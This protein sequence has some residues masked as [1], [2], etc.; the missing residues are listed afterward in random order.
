MCY[1]V[2]GIINNAITYDASGNPLTYNGYTF[3]WQRGRQLTSFSGNGQNISYTYD[4]QGRRTS[5]TV[6]G[7]TF[8]YTYSGDLL[9]RQSDGTNTLDF[10]YD[11]GGVAV[12][13][14]YNGT[15]YFY[16]RNLQGDVVAVTDADGTLVAEYAYDAWGNIMVCSGTMA[17][18]NP[19][20]Y[21]GYY[22]DPIT[23][24][25]FLQSRYYNPDWRRFL[26][27]DSLFVAGDA[28]SG[29]NMYAY[30]NGNPVMYADPSGMGVIDWIRSGWNK[31]KDA[32]NSVADAAGA[33]F[34]R[35]MD[36][37]S[38]AASAPIGKWF[39]PKVGWLV[40]NTE[41][42][43]GGAITTIFGLVGKDWTEKDYRYD[44]VKLFGVFPL[45]LRPYFQPEFTKAQTALGAWFLDFH[46]E[47]N[48]RSPNFGNFRSLP[49]SY[50]WQKNVGYDWWYDFCFSIGGQIGRVILPFVADN[51]THYAVWCWKGEYWNLG[52][53]AEIGIYYNTDAAAAD[54]GYYL[55]D[56]DNLK[57]SVLMNVTY[58]GKKITDNF[59]QTNWWITSFTPRK[60]NPDVNQ[61]FVALKVSFVDIGTNSNL[62]KPFYYYGEILHG[63]GNWS[64][65][66]WGETYNI[67]GRHTTC[68]CG[69]HPTRCTCTCPHGTC[70]RPCRAYVDY[71]YKINY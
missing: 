52:A 70:G 48:W 43:M 44:G 56:P 49:G 68:Y 71:Q 40:D 65:L 60:Q 1:T 4:A 13:F 25:Y 30:C 39:G 27:A 12:G 21:R 41:F 20:R 3:A 66:T 38:Q 26:N 32:Y 37:Q 58:K 23:G 62:M 64:N 59:A 54:Q 31:I 69:N 22:Q 63:P 55:I 17:S 9:M 67:P 24:W 53:G 47:W 29:S 14:N 19:L 18:I 11:A 51:G 2:F 45:Q 8:A 36:K 61:L 16:V 57:I 5:Q 10:Q 6:N 28:I 34:G 7:T 46:M 35:F 33:A 15:P 42:L 50:Q